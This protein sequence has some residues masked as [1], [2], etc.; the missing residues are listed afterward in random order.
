MVRQ[1]AC[2]SCSA[3]HMYVQIIGVRVVQPKAE[4]GTLLQVSSAPHEEEHK[5]QS[6][7]GSVVACHMCTRCPLA[8][9]SI[10]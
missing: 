8:Y 9:F 7:A 3:A 2:S 5:Q 1:N 6:P 10:P 4:A